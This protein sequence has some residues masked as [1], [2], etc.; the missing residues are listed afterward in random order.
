VEICRSLLTKKDGDWRPIASGAN[1]S[2]GY[3]LYVERVKKLAESDVSLGT[4]DK[5]LMPL[6]QA[7]K[8]NTR[9][10][11]EFMALTRCAE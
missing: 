3:S 9:N 6:G 10:V 2:A 7:L 4:L 11:T 1:T 8:D 5:L